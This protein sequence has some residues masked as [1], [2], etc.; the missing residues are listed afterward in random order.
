MYKHIAV[1]LALDVK[2]SSSLTDYVII[3]EGSIDR[4]I[5]A[6]A[7]EIIEKLKNMGE[8]PHYKEGLKDSDWIVLDYLNVMVHLFKPDLRDKYSLERVYED[9][10][11]VDLSINITEKGKL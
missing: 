6:I 8:K 10:K 4:H 5:K 2:K 3:A 9:S 7:D 1:L 11:I